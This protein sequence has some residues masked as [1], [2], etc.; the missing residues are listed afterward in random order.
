[1]AD[2]SLYKL[3]QK[4]QFTD[5]SFYEEINFGNSQQTSFTIN[6]GDYLDIYDT[7]FNGHNGENDIMAYDSNKVIKIHDYNTSLI[8]IIIQLAIM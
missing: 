4:T 6:L 3:N 7:Q 1:M 5:I 8:I 2:L